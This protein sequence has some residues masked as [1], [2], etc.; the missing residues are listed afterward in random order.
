MNR[1]L[2]AARVEVGLTQK[3]LAE[4][5]NMPLPTYQKK[6]QGKTQ[7]TIK[8]AGK[9]AYILNKN[10]TE[11]FFNQKVTDMVIKRKNI[12]KRRKIYE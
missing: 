3:Q 1:K 11:I 8:E 6:E 4:L 5:I 12:L 2:K 7:F 10:P 9:I